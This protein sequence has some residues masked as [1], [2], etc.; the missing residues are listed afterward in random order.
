MSLFNTVKNFVNSSTEI[1]VKDITDDSEDSMSN[2]NGGTIMNEI[3]VLTYSS[4]T[5]KEIISV[6]RKRL[7][8]ALSLTKKFSHRNCVITVKT[9]T[10]I[11]YLLN[12][13]SNEFIAWL[14]S[15]SSHIFDHLSNVE[16]D[17]TQISKV[18]WN[19][20]TQINHLAN[21]ILS[22]LNDS[23]LLERRR[24]NVIEF[25]SSISS[26]GR[27][28]T[29]NSHLNR[30]SGERSSRDGTIRGT[31]TGNMNFNGSRSLSGNRR[32]QQDSTMHTIADA[33]EE[34]EED[35]ED[36]NDGFINFRLNRHRDVTLAKNLG[37]TN[38]TTANNNGSSS[39]TTTSRMRF[40]G[41]NP[42]G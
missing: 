16:I 37:T 42:F 41:S 25:R 6:L 18:D 30:F 31:T 36:A 2:G 10:L 8:V 17:D 15:T 35:S 1:K 21:N 27:K 23:D 33:N 20:W 5:L 19:I 9:F 11:S 38:T 34:D 12:N 14:K 3:S 7:Q 22:L 4:K 13:G 28:S 32:P 26:P 40:H 24:Q 39:S 29:D